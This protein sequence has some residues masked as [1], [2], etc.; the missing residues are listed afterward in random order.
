VYAWIIGSIS[1]LLLNKD[2][3]AAELN[4]KLEAMDT[5][6]RYRQVDGAIREKI[7]DYYTYLWSCRAGSEDDMFHD[8]PEVSSLYVINRL[9]GKC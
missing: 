8:L 5:Y 1:S 9:Y 3:V 6:L 2:S 7:S 4:R